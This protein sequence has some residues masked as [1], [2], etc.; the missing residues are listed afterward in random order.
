VLSIYKCTNIDNKRGIAMY[1]HMDCLDGNCV[2]DDEI[3]G[4]YV[5]KRAMYKPHCIPIINPNSSMCDY[6]IEQVEELEERAKELAA[7]LVK[8]GR[9]QAQAQMK[10]YEDRIKRIER[11]KK[12]FKWIALAIIISTVVVVVIWLILSLV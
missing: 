5:C 2:Y 3:F 11:N 1:K 8:E 7:E 4:G 9:A 6:M 12:K 10:E